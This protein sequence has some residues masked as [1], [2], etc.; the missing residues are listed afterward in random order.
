MTRPL[1]TIDQRSVGIVL[2]EERHLQREFGGEYAAYCSRVGRWLP[3]IGS[4]G[5]DSA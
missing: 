5:S 4:R 3:R 2:Y 1:I